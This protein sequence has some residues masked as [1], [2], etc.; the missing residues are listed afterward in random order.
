MRYCNI[1]DPVKLGR[2]TLR[3]YFLTIKAVRLRLLD[4]ERDLHVGAWLNVQAKATKQRGK[5][6]IP[7]FRT[8]DEFFTHPDQKPA[9]KMNKQDE[10]KYD[11]LKE[12]LL[13]AN[14]NYSASDI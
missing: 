2:M 5:K 6:T 12:M 3:H 9:K 1:Y 10:Q 8:F 13:K 4:K 7:Y 14:T 11:A